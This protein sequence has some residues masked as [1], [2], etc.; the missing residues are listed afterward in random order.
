MVFRVTREE[1]M[2]DVHVRFLLKM[3]A[4]YRPRLE[5]KHTSSPPQSL[6]P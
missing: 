1:D 6:R 3:L 5:V 4:K 2:S